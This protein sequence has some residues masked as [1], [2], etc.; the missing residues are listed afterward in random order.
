ML[1]SSIK[2]SLLSRYNLKCSNVDFVSD[3]DVAHVA[4]TAAEPSVVM[5]FGMTEWGTRHT[6]WLW[7]TVLVA[8]TTYD[9]TDRLKN[10]QGDKQT[11]R[12]R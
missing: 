10:R 4:L 3:I 2:C 12:H 1:F 7:Q 11:Y 5:D 9:N 8:P 6:A